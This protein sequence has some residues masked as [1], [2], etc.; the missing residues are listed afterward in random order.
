[1][2]L[3]VSNDFTYGHRAI[4]ELSSFGLDGLA[5]DLEFVKQVKEKEIRAL[6]EHLAAGRAE[7]GLPG[8][9]ALVLWN[10]FHN[11]EEDAALD[12]PGVTLV[13]IFTGFGNTATKLAG[14]ST[15]QRLFGVAPKD[16]GLMAFDNRWP[17]NV[18]CKGFDTRR[19][20]DCQNWLTL[21]SEP[22]AQQVGWWVQQ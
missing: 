1:M 13:P 11:I 15:T 7:A 17:I 2:I 5:I 8:D 10:V 3:D 20:F 18:H 4:D 14:L 9:G 16:S 22:A 12:V 6:A 19:G 21:F